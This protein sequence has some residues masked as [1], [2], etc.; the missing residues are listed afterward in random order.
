VISGFSDFGTFIHL[1]KQLQRLVQL[2]MADIR[3]RLQD[4][5]A[6][7][8]AAPGGAQSPR[9]PRDGWRRAPGQGAR[10]GEMA[11]SALPAPKSKGKRANG[12]TRG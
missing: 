7:Q 4:T 2:D 6:S 12:P 10:K 1:Q 5:E 8:Q 3:Q 11:F 9:L